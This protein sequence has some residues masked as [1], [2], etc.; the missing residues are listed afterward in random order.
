MAA[1][2][3]LPECFAKNL[4]GWRA[5]ETRGACGKRGRRGAGATRRR[6][7]TA[8]QG[9]PAKSTCC[10]PD[11]PHRRQPG[12]R[13]GPRWEPALAIRDEIEA[14]RYAIAQLEAGAEELDLTDKIIVHAGA[15]A[16]AIVP[17]TN[18][19]LTKLK[20]YMS[21]SARSALGACGGPRKE[22]DAHEP[23]N[24]AQRLGAKDARSVAAALES[25][26]CRAHPRPR[27]APT[28]RHCLVTRK[29]KPPLQQHRRCRRARAC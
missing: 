28:K 8:R 27:G 11:E 15:E 22:R 20:T 7:G 10:A 23:G 1:N 5:Q 26:S 3:E 14:V 16:L 25:S 2:P 6:G 18:T 24:W 19:A 17:A 29:P 13:M 21:G 9:G 4:R 12:S